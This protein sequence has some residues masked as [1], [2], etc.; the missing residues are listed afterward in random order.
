MEN[1]KGIRKQRKGKRFNGM[2]S[3]WSFY[4]LQSFITY[5]AE[6][7][8]ITADRVKPNY[9]SQICH[10]C[11][12]LGSR[13]SQGCFSCCHCGLSNFNADLNASRNLA[14]P[15]LGERQAA[16]TQPYSRSDEAEG[17][18][19]DAIEA[20][21]YNPDV[22]AILVWSPEGA[23]LGGRQRAEKGPMTT[24]IEPD[25]PGY[26]SLRQALVHEETFWEGG[27]EQ[28]RVVPTGEV[29]VFVDRRGAE[30]R[31]LVT[32]G[33][34]WIESTLI[35]A[36][37]VLLLAFVTNRYVVRPL[38]RI[39]HAMASI[40]SR[41]KKLIRRSIRGVPYPSLHGASATT[42]VKA[43]TSK[44]PSGKDTTTPRFRQ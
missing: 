5:K 29:V 38:D 1:L 41:P 31:L 43:A 23:W 4:Q 15:M 27:M 21:L 11:G 13:S 37:L 28:T 35:V 3:N 20:E 7:K 8:G 40:T 6:R 33:K 39:R 18:S 9:T 42:I 22:A 32:L 14:H 30:E 12:Q 19:Q 17:I 16:V 2:L 26:I 36:V 24:N 25:G 10:R 34:Q 44:R